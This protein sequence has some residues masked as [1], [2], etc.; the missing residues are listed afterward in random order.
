MCDR[1]ALVSL[2]Q[3]SGLDQ[4]A[5][6]FGNRLQIAVEPATHILECYPF[7]STNEKKDADTAMVGNSLEIP[8]KLP[9]CLCSHHKSRELKISRLYPNTSF[10]HSQECWNVI[11]WQSLFGKRKEAAV[12]WESSLDCGNRSFLVAWARRCGACRA[13]SS[14]R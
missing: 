14:W 2:V 8:L 6:M 10:S 13:S 4:A 1:P 5:S 12:R 3:K 11:W 9:I 7:R